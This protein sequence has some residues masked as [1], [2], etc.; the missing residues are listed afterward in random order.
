[1]LVTGG[2]LWTTGHA[3]T[4][5][6]LWGLAIVLAWRPRRSEEAAAAAVALAAYRYYGHG[7]ADPD[8]P[9]WEEHL[10]TALREW[11]SVVGTPK[12][13]PDEDGSLSSEAA[14]AAHWVRAGGHEQRKRW[15]PRLCSLL[16]EWA[17]VQGEPED[18]IPR[19]LKTNGVE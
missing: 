4:A 12:D 17:R 11:R 9:Y 15:W 1:M 7:K 10:D 5:V 18:E 2:A 6:L 14:T 19:R 3:V 16:V 8:A 13:R